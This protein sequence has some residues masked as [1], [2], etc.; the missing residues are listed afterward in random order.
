MKHFIT[1]ISAFLL[2]ISNPSHSNAVNE[3]VTALFQH[4]ETEKVTLSPDA[5]HIAMLKRENEKLA[6]VI[7]NTETLQP[8]NKISFDKK[9]T[10]TNY[11]WVSN[12]RVV[13]AISNTSKKS[14]AKVYYGE[15]YAL[16]IDQPQGEFIF[17]FR[18]LAKRKKLKKNANSAD[19]EK[20]LAHPI[21]ID[22]LVNDP[23]NIIIATTHWNKETSFAYK[24]NV[25][26]GKLETLAH[27]K[28]TQSKFSYIE[29]DNSLWLSY[30]ENNNNHLAQFDSDK[31]AWQV[32]DFY[33]PHQKIILNAK[34]EQQTYL[35]LDYCESNYISVC[36]LNLSKKSVTNLTPE[37]KR[38]I[39]YAEFQ[40]GHLIG[41]RYYDLYPQ[42]ALV[43]DT[44]K[45]GQ[46][47]KLLLNQFNGHDIKI[48]WAKQSSYDAIVKV[49]SDIQSPLYYYF[50]LDKKK[51]TPIAATNQKAKPYNQGVTYGVA[52]E[53]SQNKPLDTYI[54]FPNVENKTKLP[55][56]VYVHGGPY[57]RS[58]WGYNPQVQY[59]THLGYAVIQVNYRGSSGYG[60][61]FKHA[62]D[63]QWGSG[64]QHDIHDAVQHFVAKDYIDANRV[65]IMGASF[66]AYSAV[67]SSILYPKSYRCA[68]ATAGVY[69]FELL[70][71]NTKRARGYLKDALK[72]QLTDETASPIANITK[73]KAP[74]LLSHGQKDTVTDYEQ[75]ELLVDA[76]KKHNKEFE[77]IPF[78]KERHA[79][80][81]PINQRKFHLRLANFLAT[82]NPL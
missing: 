79:F 19:L 60:L 25:Y 37:I 18:S 52:I 76:L 77:F 81:D 10:I 64:M 26:N 8:I 56:V 2:L 61:N 15:L 42:F 36:E 23:S 40:Q 11:T 33:N 71:K 82:H 4:N 13:L 41:Y 20:H 43:N 78:K 22:Q 58:Y 29:A 67:Q 66:G 34:R 69:D 7:F 35:F 74:L 70:H 59:L 50:S 48:Y 57:S 17:G 16:N 55:A 49:S 68:V 45:R 54:S 1:L 63:G 80:L 27:T 44:L 12:S 14:T 47:T 5:K 31:Q 30:F 65:C 75:V 72:E 53:N 62:G 32:V 24:L 21:I 46:G 38:D 39:S 28:R 51:L 73:L 6:L 3:S 9:D